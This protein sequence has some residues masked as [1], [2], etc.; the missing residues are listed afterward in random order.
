MDAKKQYYRIDEKRTNCIP[1]W[2]IGGPYY[3]LLMEGMFSDNNNPLKYK[4]IHPSLKEI[5]FYQLTKK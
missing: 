3:E 5:A 4:N 2:L 1:D